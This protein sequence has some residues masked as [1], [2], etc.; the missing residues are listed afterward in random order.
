MPTPTPDELRAALAETLTAN[1]PEASATQV[2]LTVIALRDDVLAYA[3]RVIE[4]HD[5]ELL[6][7][8]H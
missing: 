3:R 6:A 7:E 1:F 5:A 2:A 4:R 8:L